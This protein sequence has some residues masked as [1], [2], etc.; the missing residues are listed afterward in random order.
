MLAFWVCLFVDTEVGLASSVGFNIVYVLL[1]QVFVPVKS[2]SS[3]DRQEYSELQR[4]LDS[5]HGMPPTIPEDVRIFRF[6]E[7]FFFPNAYRT[8]TSI[9]DSI[10][11]HHAPAYSSRNG[12]EAERNWS[13][14]GERHV[15]RLRK[16]MRITDPSSLPPIQ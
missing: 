1:R 6:G 16:K 12:A 7:S 11:T 9:M 14:Q 13:V 15:A 10:Q 8:K 2:M 5:A 3:S 4:S